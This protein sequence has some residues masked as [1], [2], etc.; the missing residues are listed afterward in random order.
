MSRT[1]EIQVYHSRIE[2]GNGVLILKLR[3]KKMTDWEYTAAAVFKQPKGQLEIS[4]ICEGTSPVTHNLTKRNIITA[5]ETW[6]AKHFYLG[7][8]CCNRVGVHKE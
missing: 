1:F 2:R 7:V 3:H 6:I 4:G 8:G 5:V